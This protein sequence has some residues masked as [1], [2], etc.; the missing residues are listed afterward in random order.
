MT[1]LFV[2]TSQKDRSPCLEKHFREK[3]P[4]HE[5]RS[6]G[7][8]KYH[9]SRKGTHYLTQEDIEW[10]D[11]IVYAEDIH[12]AIVGR[13]FAL[14]DRHEMICAILNCG[15]YERGSVGAEYLAC[16]EWKLRPSLASNG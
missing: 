14:P 11:L 13:D 9:T 8:N 15:E 10:A 2:C 7:V 16:A 3:H 1:I 4:Q 6:A 5:Y 12:R